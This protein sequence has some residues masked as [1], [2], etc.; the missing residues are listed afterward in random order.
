[1]SQRVEHFNP[2]VPTPDQIAERA[3]QISLAR[4][5]S[6][7]HEVDDWLQAEY[8]LFQMPIQQ[9]AEL[10]VQPAS[11][12]GKQRTPWRK[13]ALVGLVQVGLV[14]ASTRFR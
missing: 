5:S 12:T 14:I 4:G 1:M 10:A 13:S 2:C 6:P 7:G 9:I 8:E 11:S 3:R